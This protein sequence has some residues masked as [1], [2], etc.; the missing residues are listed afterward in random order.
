MKKIIYFLLLSILS[1]QLVAQLP[2]RLSE[3]DLI[4]TINKTNW[5]VYF[6]SGID[7]GRLGYDFSITIQSNGKTEASWIN[8]SFEGTFYD[9]GSCIGTWQPLLTFIDRYPMQ[10]KFTPDGKSAFGSYT[11]EPKKDSKGREKAVPNKAIEI[12]P[13]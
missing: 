2:K 7:V 10:F 4:N 9:D 12:K 6:G 11:P 3:K 1:S 13:K 5:T 8:G